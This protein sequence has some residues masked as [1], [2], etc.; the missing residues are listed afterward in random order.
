MPKKPEDIYGLIRAV[1]AEKYFDTTD[2]AMATL[3]YEIFKEEARFHLEDKCWYCYDGR[4]WRE[5][6]EAANTREK[7]KMMIHQLELYARHD[8][9]LSSEEAAKYLKALRDYDRF[10]RR[11]KVLGDAA[12]ISPLKA[13]MMNVNTD[14]FNCQNGTLNLRTGELRHH[15]PYD[16]ITKISNVTYDPDVISEDFGAF[17]HDITCG[18]RELE[19]YIQKIF[20]YALCGDTS[21][22]KCFILYGPT[23]RNGKSTL[24]ETFAYM[25]GGTD[26][27]AAAVDPAT[28]ASRVQDARRASS[29][30]ARLDGFRFICAPEPPKNMIF[31]ASRLKTMTGRDKIVARGLYASEKEFTPQFKLFFNTNHL[32]EVDDQTLFDSGRMVVIPFNRHFSEAEQRPELKDILRREDNITGMFNYFLLGMHALRCEGECRPKVI[33]D[34]IEDYRL[35]SDKVARFFADCMTPTHGSCVSVGETYRAYEGWCRLNGFMAERK[36]VFMAKVKEMGI[37]KAY[38][39]INKT[40]V[41]NIISDYV[42]NN[43]CS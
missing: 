7:L 22:E 30:L 14:L 31:D 5:D 25:L 40:K 27:Y 12:S 1:Q 3:F 15:L 29:D 36:T 33:A 24:V 10:D 2:R 35:K 37:W 43:E 42:I 34:A 11:Q 28:V 23:T 6:L 41:F 17:M 21:M 32:P 26:G 20:G 38:G 16:Y 39:Y 18:D 8:A 19:F 9:D 13:S 4:V